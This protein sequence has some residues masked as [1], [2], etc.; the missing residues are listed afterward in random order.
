MFKDPM[1]LHSA[2]LAA[3]WRGA[4]DAGVT[5]TLAA[6]VLYGVPLLL[7]PSSSCY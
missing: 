1:S 6:P 4:A 3:V 5:C 2:H 7:V